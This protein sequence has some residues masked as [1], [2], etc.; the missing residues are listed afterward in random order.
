MDKNKKVVAIGEI[1]WDIFPDKKHLGGAPCNFAYHCKQLGLDSAIVSAVGRDDLGGE[2]IENVKKLELDDKFIE[3]NNFPTGTVN[4][5]LDN[6]QP[7]YEIVENVA[8]DNI[9][10]KNNLKELAKNTQVVCFGSLASRLSNETSKTVEKFIELLSDDVV[11]IFDI[12]LRQNYYS[13]DLI[14]N[15]L[16]LANVL[17]IN[18]EEINIVKDLFK[19][20]DLS[21]DD[22]LIRF[23]DEFKLDL[24]VLTKGCEGSILFDGKIKSE[25]MVNKV[26]NF[27]D[28]V[29]A[30]DSFTAVV[31]YG[32]INDWNLEKINKIANKMAALVC[33]S[34][35]GTPKIDNIEEILAYDV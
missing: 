19:W 17:K 28:A 21:E 9:N 3:K 8:W 1:L 23:Y 24:I 15:F 27:V 10:F 7:E 32:L 18:E 16:N 25:G 26:D 29:G 13:K 14:E 2:I 35:G 6:G 31:A 30:G 4:V 11:K 20:K 22:I 12:N 33:S 5:T 34:S